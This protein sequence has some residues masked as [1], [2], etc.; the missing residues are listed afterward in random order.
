MLC[1]VRKMF[2]CAVVL[3]MVATSAGRVSAD[4]V[5][6]YA[7]PTDFD[8]T[9]TVEYLTDGISVGQEGGFS[10]QFK[11]DTTSGNGCLWYL[12]DV[13]GGNS[14]EYR[15][16]IGNG[17]LYAA[18]QVGNNYAVSPSASL[19]AFTDTTSWH[20]LDLA[21]KD[22]SPTLL[23]LD[24]TLQKSLTNAYTLEA[25]TSGA[26]LNAIGATVSSTTPAY[27]FDG[28]M[29]NVAVRNTYAA[30]TPEPGTI[31]LLGTGLFGLLAY[32]WRKRR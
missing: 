2:A 24:G 30:A 29:Q 27:Y 26:G 31:V 21:W 10:C 32:A 20:T 23:T 15:V 9:S 5:A 17:A 4:T 19:T 6:S 22:G 13:A 7:G 12:A 25:F 8:G 18:L 11:A 3:A 28:Q 16:W 1:N 14:D